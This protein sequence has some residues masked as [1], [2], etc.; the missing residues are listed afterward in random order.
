MN[1]FLDLIFSDVNSILTVLIILLAIYWILT[2][3][4]GVDF[5]LDVDI[6]ID[7]DADMD[8]DIDTVDPGNIEFG[9]VASSEVQKEH[10]VNKG[11][12]RLKWWQIVLI[13]FNFV[14]LPFM[15]TFTSWIFVWWICTLLATDFT[16]TEN[17][18]IGFLFML[19]LLIPSL[20][21]NKLFTTPFKSF[22]AKLNKNGD[23]PVDF[24]G[25]TATLLSSISG[26]KLGNAEVVVDGN[27]M[28]IYVKSLD[29][30]LL[31]FRESVLI[32]KQSQDKNYYYVSK[33]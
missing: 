13:Y 7:V 12:R 8:L 29:G 23:V 14:G 16:G 30:S 1:N 22:F 4:S 9:D 2:A 21:L 19:A 10:V 17:N 11:T 33:E 25:R 28:S 3:I 5:D 18:T 26:E 20:F 24:L 15:F 27:P 31:S 32:I 6:D